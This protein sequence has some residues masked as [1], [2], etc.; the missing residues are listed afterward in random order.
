MIALIDC[1]NFY[2]SCERVFQ[3]SLQ[4]RP[5][6][7]LSNNDGCAIARSD[8][9]K[10]LGIGM[11]QPA[12]LSRHLI[13]ENKIAVQSSNYILYDSMSKRVIE[14]VQS[15][16]P[17]I[18]VYS[19]DELFAKLHHL[20]LH[21]HLPLAAT[22]REAI[23]T[24]TGIPVSIGIGATKALAKLAN[25]FA[26]K[27]DKSSGIHAC[28]SH[29]D[30]EQL[31]H[32]TAIAD[33]WGIGP[34]HADELQRNG[35]RTAYDFVTKMNEHWVREHLSVVGLRLW[36][37]LQGTSCLPWESDKPARRN[38]CTSRSFG[39][40][41]TDKKILRQAVAAFTS[42][43]AEKLRLEGNCAQTVQ[44]F[45]KTNPHRPTDPQY[46]Q[47]ITLQL[48]PATNQ[49]ATLMKQS[50]KA[51]DLIYRPGYAYQKAGVVVMDLVPD[52]QV[53]LDLFSAPPPVV[54]AA[55]HKTIDSVN[56]SFGKNMLR[57]GIHDYGKDWHLKQ[58]NKSASFTTRLSQIPKAF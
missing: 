32:D 53:Q 45:I 16:I 25:R 13:E 2:C 20:P 39:K 12:F 29:E 34:R 27:K 15:F 10:A 43:C 4:G 51:L 30:R 5:V 26:K 49:T 9:A 52:G 50:M 31:L 35:I 24:A 3:P 57:F 8:E 38:I 56:K 18:E 40:L 36:F 21:Q 54:G 58:E 17:E 44:V 55:L 23:S 33:V 48:S 28:I 47:A 46:E 11:A 19:I 7:V 22:I 37:E 1:N 6:I 42:S 14:V 41:V